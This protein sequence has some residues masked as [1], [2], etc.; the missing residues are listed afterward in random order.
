MCELLLPD[1][2]C[3]L[4][5]IHLNGYHV[6]L[7]L[8]EHLWLKNKEY[9]Y[10]IHSNFNFDNQSNEEINNYISN[11]ATK[12]VILLNKENPLHVDYIFNIIF[13]RLK[14]ICVDENGCCFIQ[15]TLDLLSN[16]KIGKM[17]IY[18]LLANTK[19]FSQHPYANYVIQYL[20]LNGISIYK[21]YIFESIKNNLLAFSLSKHSSRIIDRLISNFPD[22]VNEIVSILTTQEDNLKTLI[23]NKHGNFG[24]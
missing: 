17:I 24:K 23:F 5:M 4:L 22:V 15:R 14:D 9:D 12:E 16:E 21:F 11:Q 8:L 1:K 3:Y 6:L 10:F 18:K 7:N 13:S 20:I 19:E 2:K